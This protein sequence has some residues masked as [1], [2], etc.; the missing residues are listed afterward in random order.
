MVSHRRRCR[1]PVTEGPGVR[2]RPTSPPSGAAA[3]DRWSPRRRHRRRAHAPDAVP[4]RIRDFERW[5]AVFDSHESAHR[6]AGLRSRRLWR[7]VPEAREVFFLFD[8]DDEARARAFVTA[9]EGAEQAKVAETWTGRSTSWRTGL[10]PRRHRSV[11]GLGDEERPRRGV[12]ARPAEV[13]EVAH[14]DHQADERLG[15]AIALRRGRT[16]HNSTGRRRDR[17]ASR[18]RGPRE[19]ARRPRRPGARGRCSAAAGCPSRPG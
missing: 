7:E 10:R 6:A 4:G 12:D 18:V 11:G 5:R 17:G 19:H 13:A 3:A 2:P 15:A 9:P 16:S 14:R 1:S 8:V